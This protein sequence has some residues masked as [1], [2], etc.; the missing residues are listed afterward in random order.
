[1]PYIFTEGGLM[2]DVE[3]FRIQALEKKLIRIGG[4]ISIIGILLLIVIFET[5]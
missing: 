5:V 4:I 2:A 3:E 1:M